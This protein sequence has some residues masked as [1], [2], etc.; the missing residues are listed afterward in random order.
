MLDQVHTDM[1]MSLLRHF[2]LEFL[3][4]L[5]CEPSAS[6]KCVILGVTCNSNTD[7]LEFLYYSTEKVQLHANEL[8]QIWK[9]PPVSDLWLSLF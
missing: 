3:V 8:G 9:G 7:G 6:L 1:W 2:D 4:F 5:Y